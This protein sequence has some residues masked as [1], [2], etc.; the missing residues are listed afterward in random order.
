MRSAKPLV[1]FCAV[2]LGACSPPVRE[3]RPASA[4]SPE[5]G[6]VVSSNEEASEPHELER[7]SSPLLLATQGSVDE[8]V[9]GAE[10]E[11]APEP[12]FVRHLT[13]LDGFYSSL[14]DMAAGKRE[15]PLRVLWWGDSHTAAD[16]LTDPVREHLQSLVRD[17]GPGFFRLGLK[18]YRHDDV[19]LSMNGRWR[20]APILPAQRTRVLDGVFGLGG[21]RTLPAAG[22]SAVAELRNASEDS[23]VW[24]LSYRLPA[25]AQLEVQ[26]GDDVH[27]LK[28]SPETESEIRSDSW[29]TTGAK[30]FKVR[31]V[32]GD[33]Q[34]MGAFVERAEPG[35]VLDT[36]GIN[37]ARLATVLAWE[38][39]QLKQQLAWRNPDLL[40]LA[41]GTNEVFDNT[42]VSSYLKHFEQV[43]SL[44]REARPELPCWIVGPPDSASKSG[45]SKTRVIQVTEV[46]R[47]AA[48]AN[49]CAFSSQFELMGGE[50]SFTSWMKR[51]PALARTDRIH[52]SI[53]GYRELG[54]LVAQSL[55]SGAGEPASQSIPSVLSEP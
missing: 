55:V 44:A 23:Y 40:V 33:P 6:S 8:P 16:F 46:Q 41:F 18:G 25:G 48:Q 24:T 36:V 27:R 4:Y 49:G 38:P 9:V 22:A 26:L 1:L 53:A 11:P 13:G 37:G 34:I 51:R 54:G 39:R 10:P 50:G 42:R 30:R 31:H 2:L 32:A 15:S 17:G 43:I 12:R 35:V 28:S 19:R 14:E 3:A 47:E 20:K 52:L 45:G 7:E 21:I 29:P 5:A